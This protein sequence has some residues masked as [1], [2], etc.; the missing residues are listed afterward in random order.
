MKKILIVGSLG[1]LGT[2]LS[3]YLSERGY[4]C[5]GVDVGFF[6][7]GVLGHPKNTLKLIC[8]D[9]RSLTE[10]DLEQ[11]DAVIQLAGI[12]NDPFGNLNPETIY[13]PTRHYAIEIAKKCKK[14]GIKYLFPSSCSVYGVGNAVLDEESSVNPQTPYSL[15]KV[16]IESD[17]RELADSNF[18]P[19]ALRLATVFGYSSRMRF[20]LVINMLCGMA[21]VDKRVVLNSNGQAWRP[22]VHID[23][24]CEVFRQALE[25]DLN[26]G[27]LIVLNVGED[28]NN[29]RIIDIANIIKDEIPGC[30][31]QFL[32]AEKNI[33]DELIKDRKI[34]DGVDVRTYQVSFSKIKKV[35]PEYRAKISVYDGVIRLIKEL[36]DLDLDLIKFKQRDFY[37][38]QQIEHLYKTK[39][40]SS[41]L[42]FKGR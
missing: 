33:Q 31:L 10:N 32:S 14:L 22:H 28:R 5:A 6:Q 13:D 37:R 38:L 8:N 26:T 17:L 11:F 41:E 7:F 20:D 24:V 27:E 12:S 18:S 30:K 25:L 2:S 39:Q 1:Y 34:Q 40:I 3:D 23:D 9:A 4:T 29:L 15:N 19:I 16:Q 21:I 35:I 36:R 42:K